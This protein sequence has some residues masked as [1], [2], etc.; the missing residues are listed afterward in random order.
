MFL[1]PTFQDHGQDWP[2]LK[3][4]N[5]SCGVFKIKVAI[6]QEEL[7]MGEKTLKKLAETF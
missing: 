2:D 3:E 1:S 5:R 4:A 7:S 6:N